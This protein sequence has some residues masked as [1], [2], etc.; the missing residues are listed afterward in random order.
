MMKLTRVEEMTLSLARGATGKA[1]DGQIL[2]LLVVA[3]LAG[4]SLRSHVDLG[5]VVSA[6]CLL[7]VLSV[8]ERRQVAEIVRKLEHA[9]A[10]QSRDNMVA[11]EA[12]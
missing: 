2:T 1:G 3:L 11:A 5:M 10:D 4:S 6:A 8:L 7:G 9:R 12:H